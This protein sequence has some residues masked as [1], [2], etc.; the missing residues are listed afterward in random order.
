MKLKK[1]KAIIREHL[2]DKIELWIAKMRAN[3]MHRITGRRY[4]VILRYD[5]KLIVVDN[6]YINFYNKGLRN[7]NKRL[8][9]E[10]LMKMALYATTCKSVINR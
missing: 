4:F 1:L 6:K 3:R 2:I 7:K 10:K 9:I 5:G 8:N